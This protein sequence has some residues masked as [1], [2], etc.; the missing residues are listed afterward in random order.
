MFLN[1]LTANRLLNSEKQYRSLTLQE[2]LYSQ[3][4]ADVPYGFEKNS[5]F[6]YLGSNWLKVL[7]L[8]WNGVFPFA[9]KRGIKS[10]NDFPLILSDI[11]SIVSKLCTDKNRYSLSNTY[12]WDISSGNLVN[13]SKQY[14]EYIMQNAKCD[15]NN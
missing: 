11:N 6:V 7:G 3:I 4:N 1:I 13:V 10:P 2:A 15:L 9:L 8:D 12:A 5:I 14:R